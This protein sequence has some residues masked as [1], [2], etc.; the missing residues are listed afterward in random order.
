MQLIKTPS[1]K[2]YLGTFATNIFIQG[3]TVLQGV[4]LARLLGPSGRGEFATI[5]LWPSLF[6]GIG[7]FGVNMAIARFAGQGRWVMGL[8]RTAIKAALITGGVTVIVCGL[9]LPVLLPAEKHHLLPAAYIF[10]LFI[11]LNHLG[12]NFQGID[13]GAGNFTWLNATRAMLYPIYFAGL[14]LC[15]LYANDKVL[16]AILALLAANCSVVLMRILAKSRVFL[17]G[18][19]SPSV[20]EILTSS[21]PFVIASV[22]ALL[23]MQTDKALLVW[24]LPPE[25]IGWYVAAFA[26]ASSVNVLSSSLGVVQFSTASQAEPGHGFGELACLMRRGALASLFGACFLAIL[27]P[28]LVPLV[29]GIDF[30]AATHIA[31]ILLPGMVLSGLGNIVN[32]SL[33]GQGQPVAGVVSKVAGLVVMGL[34]GLYLAAPFGGKGIAIG[35]VAGET[36]SF[37]GQLF[38]AIRYYR[39]STWKALWPKM[40]DMAFLRQRL[41]KRKDESVL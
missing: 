2:V 29:Y 8:S 26:A 21:L 36:V 17:S 23:Y 19:E 11:P 18:G 9:A 28:W 34:L 39:D 38:V 33:R 12:M 31:L 3:C 40:E 32:Q 20:H 10:L 25:E 5:I 7:I 41:I 22:I 24:L 4:L 30:I 6:A 35:Y 1:S 27:L 16:C 14:I 13:H 37:V 15:W